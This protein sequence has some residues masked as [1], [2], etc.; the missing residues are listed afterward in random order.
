MTSRRLEKEGGGESA[1]CGNN[2]LYVDAGYRN[3]FGLAGHKMR[4]PLI[5]NRQYGYCRAGFQHNEPI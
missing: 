1:P 5:Y 4:H 3:G 2:I